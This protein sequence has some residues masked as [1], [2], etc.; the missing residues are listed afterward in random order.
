MLLGQ[1]DLS[2]CTEAIWGGGLKSLGP[3]GVGGCRAPGPSGD[4]VGGHWRLAVLHGA[5]EQGSV[6]FSQFV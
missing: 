6:Y 1:E 2:Q 4:S 5:E 3:S